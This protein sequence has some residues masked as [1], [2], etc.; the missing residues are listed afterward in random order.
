M[1]TSVNAIPKRRIRPARTE[2]NR[3]YYWS[4]RGRIL[5][6]RKPYYRRN[7]ERENARSMAWQRANPGK[8]QTIQ[9]RRYQR[10]RE[11]ILADQKWARVAKRASVKASVKAQMQLPLLAPGTDLAARILGSPAARAFL[12]QRI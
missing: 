12:Q 3:G 1:R 4:N 2:Y 7:R 11:T 5:A 8:Y 6:N 10:N 9:R